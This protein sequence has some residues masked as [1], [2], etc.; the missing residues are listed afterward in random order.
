MLIAILLFIFVRLLTVAPFIALRSPST[1][2][3]G[4]SGTYPAPTLIV[5]QKK[6]RVQCS[7]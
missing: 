1:T 3:S 6:T 7:P 2:F 5:L 4:V